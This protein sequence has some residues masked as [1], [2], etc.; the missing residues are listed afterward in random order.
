MSIN[1]VGLVLNNK[2]VKLTSSYNT[3]K[4]T[5]HLFNL[6]SVMTLKYETFTTSDSETIYNNYGFLLIKLLILK[7]F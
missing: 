3:L 2:S 4:I 5:R 6:Q 1:L 7:V